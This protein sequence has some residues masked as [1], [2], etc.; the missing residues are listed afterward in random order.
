M[1]LRNQVLSRYPGFV[2]N[3]LNS[4]S[5]EVRLLAN[6]V[7]RDPQS[8]TCRNIKYLEELTSLSPWD[9]SGQAMRKKVPVKEIPEKSKMENW[10]HVKTTGNQKPKAFVC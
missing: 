10:V 7:A 4:P 2:Q 9:F 3:L 1:S 5:R 8:T 6:I